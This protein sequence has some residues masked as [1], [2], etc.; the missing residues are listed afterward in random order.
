MVFIKMG[1]C[2]SPMMHHKEVEF[3]DGYSLTHDKSDLHYPN[4]EYSMFGKS[5]VHNFFVNL[6]IFKFQTRQWKNL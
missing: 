6:E 4:M 2:F 5:F 1:E 3:Q